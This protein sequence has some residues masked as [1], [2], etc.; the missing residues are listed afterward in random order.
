MKDNFLTYSII[1]LRHDDTNFAAVKT[2]LTLKTPNL[3]WIILRD[4]VR[5]A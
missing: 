1:M 4:S 2:S 3:S 5:T